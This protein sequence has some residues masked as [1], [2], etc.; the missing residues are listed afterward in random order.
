MT[1]P[2]VVAFRGS[3]HVLFGRLMD[4]PKCYATYVSTKLMELDSMVL[5]PEHI[6]VWEAAVEAAQEAAYD[7]QHAAHL[8]AENCF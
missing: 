2:Y 6:P 4:C 3:D 8:E 1:N 7:E 5:C